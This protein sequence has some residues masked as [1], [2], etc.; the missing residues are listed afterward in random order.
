MIFSFREISGMLHHHPTPMGYHEQQMEHAHFNTRLT[1]I[2]EGQQ[3]IQNTLH[4]HF[5]WQ[6]EAR[7]RI[8]AIQ[9]QQQQENDNWNW[10]F[11]GLNIDPHL[12]EES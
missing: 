12:V 9:Q 1:T 5:Q 8:A 3:E 4:Q 11:Q 6:E 7:Q 10:L 2:E